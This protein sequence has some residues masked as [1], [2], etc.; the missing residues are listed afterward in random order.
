VLLSKDINDTTF[1]V[2]WFLKF[3]PYLSSTEKKFINLVDMLQILSLRRCKGQKSLNQAGES[4][5]LNAKCV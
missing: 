1:M 5:G 3:S 4:D 2:A